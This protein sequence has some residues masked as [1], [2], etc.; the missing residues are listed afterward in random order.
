MKPMKFRFVWLWKDWIYVNTPK[1]LTCNMTKSDIQTK[2]TELSHK[3]KIFLFLKLL[4]KLFLGKMDKNNPMDLPSWSNL[5]NI[6]FAVTS[7][8]AGNTIPFS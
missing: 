4:K 5:W 1:R 2:M 3:R 8:V 6:C 7:C